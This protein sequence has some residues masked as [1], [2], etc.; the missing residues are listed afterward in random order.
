[1]VDVR[2]GGRV[3]LR[4]C[5]LT[6]E[7]EKSCL[8]AAGI[9]SG[10]ATDPMACIFS[11]LDGSKVT[12][13]FCDFY[14][15]PGA[16]GSRSELHCQSSRFNRNPMIADCL[17]APIDRKQ[18]GL[19]FTLTAK[20]FVALSFVK[21][22][23]GAG[24]TLD[25]SNSCK[26][27]MHGP[28]IDKVF[29]PL[30]NQ[31][32]VPSVVFKA[33]TFCLTAHSQA[34]IV[35]PIVLNGRGM[36][37]TITSGAR[38]EHTTV[39]IP[40]NPSMYSRNGG[41]QQQERL[42]LLCRSTGENLISFED[43]MN[44]EFPQGS[45]TESMGAAVSTLLRDT[46]LCSGGQEGKPLLLCT[47]SLRMTATLSDNNP[48]G[49]QILPVATS[50]AM[51]WKNADYSSTLFVKK[52]SIPGIVRGMALVQVVED[53]PREVRLCPLLQP[54]TIPYP[55]E[56]SRNLTIGVYAG[57]HGKSGATIETP[58]PVALHVK[59][60]I[61]LTVRD[62][63]FVHTRTNAFINPPGDAQLC[64]LPKPGAAGVVSQ[65]NIAQAF[66]LCRGKSVR[67][68]V[69]NCTFTTD[70]GECTS[71]MGTAI[72]ENAN[73]A[74]FHVRTPLLSPLP[75]SAS[76]FPSSHHLP[77]CILTRNVLQTELPV[78]VR[79]A[80]EAPLRRRSR[81]GSDR[82]RARHPHLDGSCLGAS[83]HEGVHRCLPR[84]CSLGGMRRHLRSGF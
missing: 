74:C 60:G 55:A 76:L 52:D 69:N 45:S 3:E 16:V 21:C 6:V 9:K 40:S 33:C 49:C 30:S 42:A 64:V 12:A 83:A 54:I 81:A 27:Y 44:F 68:E 73:N 4:N 11:I 15:N 84:D 22:T 48:A 8:T 19:R 39:M 50:T 26:Q 31:L 47:E 32:A 38:G 67:L 1:M 70:L 10:I 2:G 82:A 17:P 5:N 62:I 61:Q 41:T 58:C 65:S 71:T 59:E 63:S 36:Q 53:G 51:L 14:G 25:C 43:G 24:F 80:T 20:E 7:I 34:R 18:L 35:P 79:N 77:S 29:E 66:F 23:L 78:R 72:A 37:L 13:N 46:R 28:V 75:S 56:V 57:H